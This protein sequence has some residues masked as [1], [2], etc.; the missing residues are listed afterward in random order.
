MTV[1]VPSQTR[2]R[3]MP[4]LT[5]RLV[6]Q[7]AMRRALLDLLHDIPRYMIVITR[8]RFDFTSASPQIPKIV[9]NETDNL[10]LSTEN[11]IDPRLRRAKRIQFILTEKDGGT[12]KLALTNRQVEIWQDSPLIRS[13]IIEF[14]RNL[15]EGASIGL[16]SF[17]YAMLL[18]LIPPL[19]ALGGV[20]FWTVTNSR[21]RHAFYVADKPLTNYPNPAWLNDYGSTM[22]ILWIPATITAIIMMMIILSS[23]PL[24]I[25]PQSLTMKSA[26]QLALSIRV[27]LFTREVA[28]GVAIAVISAIA[29]VLLTRILCLSN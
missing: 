26:L 29:T 10:D 3:H 4:T 5:S 28:R 15:L 19:L 11:I 27:T 20:I 16:V 14:N 13:R 23:G 21:V 25:W 2:R 22:I 8:S 1:S 7:E 12:C 24:R 6:R 9:L 17:G 18:V